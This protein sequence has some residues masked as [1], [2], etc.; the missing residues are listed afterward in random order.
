[1]LRPSFRRF[2]VVGLCGAVLMTVPHLA[3]T[4]P[5]VIVAATQDLGAI[6]APPGVSARDGGASVRL[7]DKILWT[8]GDTLFAPAVA[9]GAHLRSNTAALA[10]PDRPLIVSEPL[11]SRGAPY[12]FLPFTADEAAYNAAHASLGDRVAL[13]PGSIVAAEDGSGLVFYDKLR[14]EPGI[15]NYIHLGIGLAH[16]DPDQTMA[17]RDPGLLFGASEPSFVSA[18]RAGTWLYVYGSLAGSRDLA[19]VVGRVSFAQ[20]RERA[21][22]RFWDGVDWNADVMRAVPVMRHIPGALTVSYNAYLR[23]YVAV[24]SEA[25]SNRVVLQTAPALEGPWSTPIIGFTGLTPAKDSVDYAAIEHPELSTNGGQ[26]IVITYYHPL[27]S[28]KGELRL[29]TVTFS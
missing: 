9:D 23:T 11:D 27:G 24:H 28:L 14:V 19:V 6:G 26:T 7:D 3:Q 8:F 15:L 21:A 29:V 20:V 17:V 16:V 1:M 18:V 4:D 2:F 10:D 13:W 5:P 22:Y 25:L 12:P